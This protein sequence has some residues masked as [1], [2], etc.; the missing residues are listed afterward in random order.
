[1]QTEH[2][3]LR[4]RRRLMAARI[5]ERAH[6]ARLRAR[7]AR[8]KPSLR[9]ALRARK[10]ARHA[11]GNRVRS[12]RRKV[13]HAQKRALMSRHRAR[14]ARGASSTNPK[15]MRYKVLYARRAARIARAKLAREAHNKKVGKSRARRN[16]CLKWIW[17]PHSKSRNAKKSWFSRRKLGAAV[18]AARA[19]WRRAH[20]FNASTPNVGGG[21]S[22]PT[23]RGKVVWKANRGFISMTH[24][25]NVLNLKAYCVGA[26]SAMVTARKGNGQLSSL[27]TFLYRFGVKK[28]TRNAFGEYIALVKTYARFYK[29]GLGKYLLYRMR[30]AMRYKGGILSWSKKHK[31]LVLNHSRLGLRGQP[32]AFR[33]WGV[34]ARKFKSEVVQVR[35]LNA[36][37]RN[38]VKSRA[39][40]KHTAC[41]CTATRRFR[42]WGTCRKHFKYDK[43]SW[44]QVNA[45]CPKASHS[46]Q[47]FKW[48]YC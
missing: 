48:K 35:K 8:G 15:E 7:R 39:K 3:H 36:A 23:K 12:L 6:K 11:R 20:G 17:W 32:K 44:C 9:A 4:H 22:K 19:A 37:L 42:K 40:F 28:R 31:L 1:M 45:K 21:R 25:R 34:T 18:S 33:K 27:G 46:K 41:R 10:R 14:V 13:S 29:R 38:A 26:H 2:G 16:G 24:T 47:G 43:K 5:R 30:R